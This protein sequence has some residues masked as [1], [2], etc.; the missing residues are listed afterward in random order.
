MPD[1]ARSLQVD[2]QDIVLLSNGTDRFSGKVGEMRD[3][4]ISLE[5]KYGRFQFMLEDIAEIRFARERLA[6]AED[7]PADNFVVRLNPV[8]SI[9][10]RPVSGD[11]SILGILSPII[12]ELNLSIDSA[13][14]LDFNSSNQIIDDWDAD[15]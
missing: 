15:F 14:M 13:I 7:L 4:K 2:D 12:G 6:P 10:G 8:G 11:A 1:S 3:G 9:S 5:G